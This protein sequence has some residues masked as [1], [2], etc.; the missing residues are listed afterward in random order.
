MVLLALEFPREDTSCSLQKKTETQD[1][2]AEINTALHEFLLVQEVSW[3]S[4]F[5]FFN[6][7]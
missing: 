6:L 4:S 7:I 2:D 1:K 3:K 5:F